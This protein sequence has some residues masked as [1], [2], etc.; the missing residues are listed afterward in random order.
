M[1]N[2]QLWLPHMGL[3]VPEKTERAVRMIRGME[4]KA[5]ELDP[6]DGYFLAFSGGKDSIVIKA[7]AEMASVKFKAHYSVTTI[8]PPELLQFIREHHPDVAWK[9]PKRS[10]MKAVETRGIPTRLLRWCCEEFKE[11]GG[12]DRF[13]ILGIRAAESPRRAANWRELDR[14]RGDIGLVLN[15][16][17]QWSDDDVW[18]FI[19]SHSIPYCSL[20]DEG[21]VRLGCIGCPMSGKKGR[22]QT[23]DR[24]P[25]YERN[26]QRA[27]QKLW[28]KKAGKIQR[29]GRE[30]VGSRTFDSWEE[31]WDWWLSEEGLSKD[32]NEAQACLGHSRPEM[33]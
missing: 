12:K 22:R 26:W 17:L 3:T 7:L 10:M 2:R 8:D 20:Y 29:D 31:M 28:K 19:H 18:E 16:I 33:W 32:D 15:P 13:K 9:R 6:E 30:W 27:L 23:F 24:W 14:W 11:P 1:A 21:F 4:E 5:L 25:A